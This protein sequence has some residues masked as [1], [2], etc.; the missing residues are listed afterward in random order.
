MPKVIRSEQ[1]F[2][3]MMRKVDAILQERHVPIHLRELQALGE[4]ARILDINELKGGPLVTGAVPGV[5]EGDSLSAHI[6][7]WIRKRYDKR[8]VVDF[9]NGYSVLILRGD[10]WLF[11][12]PRVYGEF[13]AVCE[14]N[15]S[16]R[17]PNVVTSTG[18][19]PLPRLVLNVLHGIE[20]L[21]QVLASELSDDELR[22][23]LRVFVLGHDLFTALG[24]HCRS[25]ELAT[26]ALLDYNSSARHC[27]A[28]SRE[29]GMSRWASLQAAEK[30]LKHYLIRKG[31]KFRYTHNLKELGEQAHQS[32]LPKIDSAVLESVQCAPDVRYQHGAQALADVV[33][34][35]H[36]A[37]AIGSIVTRTL[38]PS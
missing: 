11:Q 15:L 27:A 34:A 18:G 32:A 6:F 35:N 38:Y 12:Y 30:L 36:N 20:K 25:D 16:I 4:A 14:R 37:M 23:V 9:S 19:K 28:G 29:Y 33:R 21:S 17:F 31:K 10:A 1:E 26:A 2:D 8:L 5:Y 22:E 7:Q 3:A 13:R 24:S